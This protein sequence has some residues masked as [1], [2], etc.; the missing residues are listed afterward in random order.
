MMKFMYTLEIITKAKNMNKLT[1][2]AVEILNYMADW[3]HPAN[4]CNGSESHS[5]ALCNYLNAYINGWKIK[6]P[7]SAPYGMAQKVW[8]DQMMKELKSIRLE[9]D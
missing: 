8:F 1:P 6:Y 5:I 4:S 3:D 2:R 9:K 7:Q